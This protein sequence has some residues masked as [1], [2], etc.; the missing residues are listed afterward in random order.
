M[1]T[2]R[3]AEAAPELHVDEV[4]GRWAFRYVEG[5]MELNSD[6]TVATREEATDYA[7]RAY[8]DV[9]LQD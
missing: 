3:S 8:P 1:K 6:E 5:D 2:H 7:R 9:E 4:E